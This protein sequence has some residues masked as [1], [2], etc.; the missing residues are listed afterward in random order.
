MKLKV[1]KK[2]NKQLNKSER[3]NQRL[4][5]IQIRPRTMWGKYL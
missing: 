4:F 3:K 5:R 1:I 2:M